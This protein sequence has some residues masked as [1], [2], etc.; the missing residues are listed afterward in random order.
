MAMD[1]TV[2]TRRVPPGFIEALIRRKDESPDGTA[3]HGLA[4]D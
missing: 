4:L 3:N 2:T 1:S